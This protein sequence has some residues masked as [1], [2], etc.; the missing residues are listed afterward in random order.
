MLIEYLNT[1]LDL[2]SMHDLTPLAE[3]LEKLGCL[4]LHTARTDNG[5]WLASFE[6]AREFAAPEPCILALLDAVDQLS[7]TQRSNWH[8]CTKREF[9]IGFNSGLQPHSLGLQLS[10]EVLRRVAD[11]GAGVGLTIYRYVSEGESG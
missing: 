11:A 3:E 1:D 8:Q 9:N 5:L 2:E 4:A 7:T 6:T 10:N